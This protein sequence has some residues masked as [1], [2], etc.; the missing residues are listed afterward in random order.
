[1]TV[2]ELLKK[3]CEDL[4]P[5]LQEMLMRA[6]LTEQC[7]WCDEDVPFEI[8]GL[9]KNVARTNNGAIVEGEKAKW[10]LM[11]GQ[12]VDEESGIIKDYTGWAKIRMAIIGEGSRSQASLD[13]KTSRLTGDYR[14]ILLCKSCLDTSGLKTAK[15]YASEEEGSMP[16]RVDPS[17]K[18]E[19]L[20]ECCDHHVRLTDV[21]TRCDNFSDLR[22]PVESRSC[23][24]SHRARISCK[25]CGYVNS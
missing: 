8:V 4:K 23:I 24:S 6:D 11:A 12:R 21:C 18:K 14:S 9:V 25:Y 16:V 5:A 19:S 2:D 22:Y 1:M 20:D 15:H 3:L 7:S 13:G 17:E 10:R